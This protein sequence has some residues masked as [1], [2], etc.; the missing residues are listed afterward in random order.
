MRESLPPSH[1][2]VPGGGGASDY[3]KRLYQPL[4]IIAYKIW[5][6]VCPYKLRISHST[7]PI[8][9]SKLCE[10]LKWHITP[11]IHCLAKWTPA[12]TDCFSTWLMWTIP[13]T[14]QGGVVRLRNI[15]LK[16]KNTTAITKL[17]PWLS[18]TDTFIYVEALVFKMIIFKKRSHLKPCLV[19][20]SCQWIYLKAQVKTTSQH[21]N[22]ERIYIVT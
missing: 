20:Q 22:Y 1:C 15:A 17:N 4:A 7:L 11:P 9:K 16:K 5:H 8:K 18:R 2:V 3:R 19:E 21:K 12:C 13:Q 6:S 14:F 10:V